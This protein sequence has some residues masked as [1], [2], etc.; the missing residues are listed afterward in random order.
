MQNPDRRELYGSL[1]AYNRDETQLESLR[2][3]QQ[4]KA[5]A[6]QPDWLQD[7]KVEDSEQPSETAE[8]PSW[9]EQFA[10]DPLQGTGIPGAATPEPKQELTIGERQRRLDY[11]GQEAELALGAPIIQGGIT[12]VMQRFRLQAG[13]RRSDEDVM[14]SIAEYVP[15]AEIKKVELPNKVNIIAFKRPGSPGYEL[16]NPKGPDMGDL[17]AALSYFANLEMGASLA[18]VVATRGLGFLPRMLSQGIAAGAGRFGDIKVD[19][20]MGDRPRPI[21]DTIGDVA[22][23][24][25]FGAGGEALGTAVSKGVNVARGAGVLD[26]APATREAVEAGRE[27]GLTGLTVG[28]RHPLTRRA[29]AL[30]AA[31]TEPLQEQYA[32]QRRGVFLELEAYRSGILGRDGALSGLSDQQLDSIIINRVFDIRKAIDDPSVSLRAG[33]RALEDAKEDFIIASAKRRDT[34]YAKAFELAEN[35]VMF[36]LNPAFSAINDIYKGTPKRAPDGSISRAEGPIDPTLERLMLDV[37]GT[38]ANPMG[39]EGYQELQVL[40]TRAADIMR[41]DY[42][43]ADASKRRTMTEAAK[44]HAALTETIENASAKGR[45]TLESPIEGSPNEYQEIMTL[46]ESDFTRAWKRANNFNSWRERVLDMDLM[47]KIGNESNP[48]MLMNQFAK[49][50]EFQSLRTL[51]RVMS[52]K[53]WETFTDAFQTKLRNSPT[54]ILQTFD[55]F[56]DEPETL[57][58]LIP[59]SKQAEYRILGR[60][61]QRL[62]QSQAIWASQTREGDR[63]LSLIDSNNKG[64]LEL[65]IQAAGG[66]D[67]LIGKQIRAGIFQKLLDRSTEVSTFTNENVINTGKLLGEIDRYLQTDAFVGILTDADL[68]KLK[69]LR[70]Y[71]QGIGTIG[72][73]DAGTSLAGTELASGFFNVLNLD[74]MLGAVSKQFKNA[75][76]ARLFLNERASNLIFGR[77]VKYE[78]VTGLRAASQILSNLARDTSQEELEILQRQVMAGELSE[79]DI[80]RSRQFMGQQ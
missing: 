44:L 25:I 64:E 61:A 51:K 28:Q 31:T 57:D 24:A 47:S 19:E 16:I 58:L 2:R 18:T 29:E 63:A 49:P 52:K 38:E 68:V 66:P 11:L 55:S 41:G 3:Q 59:P 75:L 5:E 6:E 69:K 10:I 35:D 30:F 8:A 67:S 21:E 26:A 15:G 39:V 78:T 42:Q 32:R 17:G 13:G 79:E 9:L 62:K 60:S 22:L 36:D 40:R 45:V 33:S 34:H 12:D 14:D 73:S 76:A 71:V 43:A 23:S 48:V 37:R 46:Q 72:D 80:R 65:A 20:L 54:K 50:G 4:E 74:A 77:G 70:T 7:F 56:A 53:N 1:E 27:M